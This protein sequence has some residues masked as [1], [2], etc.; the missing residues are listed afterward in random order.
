[1]EQDF[2][3][4]KVAMGTSDEIEVRADSRMAAV[5]QALEIVFSDA[6]SLG[7]H[8]TLRS[9]THLVATFPWFDHAEERLAMA[10]EPWS[11]L[12]DQDGGVWD[13][14]EQHWYL[15]T[16]RV[17]NQVFVFWSDFDDLTDLMP[18]VHNAEATSIEGSV[19]IAGVSA[20]WSCCD[21]SAFRD[22]W[23]V[24]QVEARRLSAAP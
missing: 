15:W 17:G 10:G 4:F 7:W 19:V 18:G 22:A 2:A 14:L 21:L 24:A 13:D 23:K 3:V 11:P 20:R 8:V 5:A 16:C 12:I 9:A 1:V 6:G